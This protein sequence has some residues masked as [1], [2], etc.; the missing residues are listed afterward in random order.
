MIGKSKRITMNGKLLGIIR[1]DKVFWTPKKES[2][3]FRMYN[4]WGMNAKLY[5]ELKDIVAVWEIETEKRIYRIPFSW[6]ERGIPYRNPKN[7][8]D[9]QYQVPVKLFKIYEVDHARR[10]RRG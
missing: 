2:Q 9:L 8:K 7:E 1:K 6:I 5:R 10:T 3:R 4:S